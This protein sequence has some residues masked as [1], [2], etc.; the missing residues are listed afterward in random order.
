MLSTIS[1]T[2]YLAC[3][4]LDSNFNITGQVILVKGGGCDIESKARN[5]YASGG[6]GLLLYNDMN[7]SLFLNETTSLRLPIPV[8]TLSYSEGFKLT[9]SIETHR[10]KGNISSPFTIQFITK[11]VKV[12]SAGAASRLVFYY[13]HHMKDF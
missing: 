9:N 3:Q 8:A 1:D 13:I 10:M 4:L 7:A 6:A 12:K 5:V 11:M 2:S